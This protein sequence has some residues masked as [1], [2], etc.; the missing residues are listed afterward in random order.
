MTYDKINIHKK[1]GLH[2]LS[3]I[4]I[5]GKTRGMGGGAGGAGQFVP[6]P[7]CRN[8][9]DPVTILICGR[10]KMSKIK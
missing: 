1:P 10:E 6:A 8:P 9:R 2:H 3:E 5:F 4:Y 7:S